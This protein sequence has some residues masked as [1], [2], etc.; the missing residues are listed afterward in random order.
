MSFV[1]VKNYT[2]KYVHQEEDPKQDEN[3]KIKGV[4]S[5]CVV[6]IEHHIWVV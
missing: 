1:V 3:N 5:A 6:C 4:P 2:K